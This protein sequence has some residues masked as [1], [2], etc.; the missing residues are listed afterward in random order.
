MQLSL[1]VQRAVE[2][3][4]EAAG[5]RRHGPCRSLRVEVWLTEGQRSPLHFG[6]KDARQRFA[7]SLTRTF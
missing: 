2:Q 6:G 4:V 5:R 1:G 7:R 3:R